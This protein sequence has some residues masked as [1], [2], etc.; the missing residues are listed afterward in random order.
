ML[1]D[2]FLIRRYLLHE[3]RKLIEILHYECNVFLELYGLRVLER[4]IEL[5]QV[6]FPFRLGD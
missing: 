4:R 5:P 6:L 2:G 3:R 1:V